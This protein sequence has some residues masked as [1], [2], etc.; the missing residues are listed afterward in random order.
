[1]SIVLVTGTGTDI[2]KTIG[3]AALAA[4]LREEGRQVHVVKPI[5]TGFPGPNGGDLDTVAELTGIDNLH[6]FE[7]YPEPMAPV[8]AAQ[9]AGMRLPKATE[10]AEKIK[11]IDGPNRVVFVEGAGGLLVRLGEDW[12]LPELAALLPGSQM[13]VVTR[14]GLGCLNEAELTVEVA[15]GRGVN[16]TALVGGSLPAETDPIIET[17]LEE[18]PRI[19][20]VPLLGS[21]QAGAGTLGQ[22]E[23]V[24]KATQW[25]PGVREWAAAL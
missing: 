23:F 8:A 6:G 20:G 18:L 1:M 3:T 24:S 17:N 5:Q 21:V 14:L 11:L 10:I 4:A 12:A 2:G 9:R 22:Q 7:R 16:V 19:T 15:R 25:L 13:V